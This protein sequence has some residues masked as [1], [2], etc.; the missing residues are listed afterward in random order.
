MAVLAAVLGVALGGTQASASS[1]EG[2]IRLAADEAVCQPALVPLRPTLYPAHNLP[3]GHL[4]GAVVLPSAA[5]AGPLPARTATPSFASR[6]CLGTRAARGPPVPRL[7]NDV[8][9]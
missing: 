5:A 9:T 4:P 6:P 2:G 8:C 7:L 1:G 3:P